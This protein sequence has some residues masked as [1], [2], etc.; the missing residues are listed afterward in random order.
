MGYSA[1][2]AIASAMVTQNHEGSRMVAETFCLIGTMR[3]LTHSMQSEISEQVV[4][5]L[6]GGVE[7]EPSL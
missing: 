2:S 4:N 6:G 5:F 3:F 1:K 7:D